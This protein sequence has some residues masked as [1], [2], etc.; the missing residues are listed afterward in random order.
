MLSTL[1]GRKPWIY[2]LAAK[3]KAFP[4]FPVTQIPQ[5]FPEMMLVV[6]N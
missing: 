6:D 5:A 3:V 2:Q 4:G 1:E